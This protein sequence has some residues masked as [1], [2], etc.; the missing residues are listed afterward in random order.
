MRFIPYVPSGE[1]CG[2]RTDD[3]ASIYFYR[4]TRH[5]EPPCVLHATIIGHSGIGLPE[6]REIETA[7]LEF[8]GAGLFGEPRDGGGHQWT[9]DS[10]KF[11]IYLS[12]R[13]TVIIQQDGSGIYPYLLDEL[14]ADKTWREICARLTPE[15][16]WNL[17]ISLTSTYRKGRE[18][19][20]NRLHRMF[21]EGKLKKRQ[22]HNTTSIV[23][24]P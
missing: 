15:L 2:W 20:R 5:P 18:D 16:L 1:I 14:E 3:T 10:Y 21:L 4:N 23:E 6:S 8:I 9:G 22:R 19:E 17:C 11:G 13:N 12:G 7:T 24:M